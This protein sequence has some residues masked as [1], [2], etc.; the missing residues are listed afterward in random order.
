MLYW[1]GETMYEE[2][3]TCELWGTVCTIV[4]SW[5]EQ[6]IFFACC[7]RMS[8]TATLTEIGKRI[9]TSGDESILRM[10]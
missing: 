3:F 9:R 2:F 4:H 1:H 8:M 10:S 5:S 6:S 7:S